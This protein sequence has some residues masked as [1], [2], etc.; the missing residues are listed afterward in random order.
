MADT[1]LT[2]LII[3]MVLGFLYVLARDGKRRMDKPKKCESC[4]HEEFKFNSRMDGTVYKSYSW[5]CQG[6]GRVTCVQFQDAPNLDKPKSE[7]N[8]V[9][10]R[11]EYLSHRSYKI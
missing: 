8:K 5:I 4:K 7:S 10:N 9:G 11:E 1:M 2:G 6:C 3:V